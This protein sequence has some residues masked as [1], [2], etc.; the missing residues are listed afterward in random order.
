MYHSETNK[1]SYVV[2]AVR[3]LILFILTFSYTPKLLESTKN[4]SHSAPQPLP[5]YCVICVPG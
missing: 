3:F 5:L 2:Y 1:V 4:R